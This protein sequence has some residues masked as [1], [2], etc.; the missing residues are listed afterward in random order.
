[1]ANRQGVDSA[2]IGATK[3]HQLDDNLAALDFKIPAELLSRLDELSAPEIN[4]PYNFFYGA[5]MSEMVNAGTKVSQR[6][7][8]AA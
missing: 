5:G 4:Y 1:V 6:P 3:L 8:I 2:I 7:A